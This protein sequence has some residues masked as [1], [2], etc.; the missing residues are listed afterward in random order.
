MIEI[1][2]AEVKITCDETKKNN[3]YTVVEKARLPKHVI[4]V[5]NI[6]ALF[7]YMQRIGRQHRKSIIAAGKRHCVI[8]TGSS[9]SFLRWR[10]LL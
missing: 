7:G 10:T 9:I 3:L 1:F 8:S 6:P 2:I 4:E 5:N